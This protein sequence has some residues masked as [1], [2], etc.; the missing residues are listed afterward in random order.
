MQ[1]RVLGSLEVRRGDAPVAIGS[2][3]QRAV[4][5][6]LLAE[7]GKVVPVD[8]LVEALWGAQPPA[9][10]RN[11][12]Q[13]YVA[14]LREK[15]GPDIPIITRAPGYALEV[16][17]RQVDAQRFEQLLAEG[18]RRSAEPAAARV[19]LDRALG[20]W[21]GPAYAEFADDVARAEA[22][23]LAERRRVAIEERA[24][25]RLAL[26]EAADLVGELSAALDAEPL[27]ERLVGLLM[28]ALAMADRQADALAVYRRYRERLVDETGLEPSP[29]VRALEARVLRGE[30][31]EPVAGSAA[32][33]APSPASAGPA[34]PRV[35]RTP[36]GT[37]SAAPAM[38]TSLVGR[39]ADIADVRA[40]LDRAGVVTLTGPGGVGKTRIAAE[41]ARGIERDGGEV[42]WVE[43]A[44]VGDPAAVDHVVAAAV[45]VDLT[46]GQ[47][48]RDALLQALAPRTLLLVLDNCEHLPE[49]VAPL[50]DAIGRRCP[51]VRVLATGRERL[52]IDGEWLHPVRP[53]AVHTAAG[54]P[55]GAVRLFA[56]RA[57]AANASIDL[58]G[59]LDVVSDICRHVDGLPL[60]IELAAARTSVLGVDDL[61]A[62]LH[63]DL[64][65]AGHRRGGSERHRD[66]WAVADWSYRLLSTDE[67][68]LFER[69]S[70]F[71]GAFGADEAHAVCAPDGQSRPATVQQLATLAEGSV[72][73]FTGQGRY[74]MLRPLR[75]FARQRL[76]DR[77]ELGTVAD[78]HAAL[79][80]ECAEQAGGPPLTDDGRRWLEG[81]L[82]DLRG[83]RQRARRR[84]D[85][86]LLGRLVAALYRFD[87]WR[88]G[89]ELLGWADDA[90]ELEGMDDEPTA[91]QVYAAAATAA[92]RRGDLD[93]ARRLADR[94]IDLSPG[95]DDPAMAVPFE[96]L[97]DVANF[98][99]RLAEAEAA[100]REQAR[101]ARLGGDPD[102]EVLGMAS[103]ALVVAYAGRLAEG[104]GQA[105]AAAEAAAGAGPAVRA[106][107]RYAQGECRAE[108]APEEAQAILDDAG[109]LASA[110]GASFVETVA[111][112]TG[113][114]LRGRSGDPAAA[115][116][117][118]ADVIEG[119][120]RSGNW[121]QQWTTLRNFV[122]L[123]V[124]L[125]A[126]EPAVVIAAAAEAEQTAAPTFGA[127]GERL[128]R[129][130]QAAQARLGDLRAEAARARGPQLTA[131]EV[132]D[133]ALATIADLAARQA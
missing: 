67:Q 60:A 83:A 124:R 101:L 91:P 4:L 132:V 130:L 75:A 37:A 26:G 121:T 40:L 106:F 63:A 27:R 111:R 103:G 112:L 129:A 46:G 115:L 133:L 131:D 110:C 113:T 102:G 92:W 128:G 69:L 71:A 73:T 5:V 9:D 72:L 78:R 25:A 108:T 12:I 94:G 58:T 48:S 120:R 53:L 47:P 61:R 22:L 64:A 43:L 23:R 114:S 16:A 122:E 17:P 35:E 68:Q 3:R 57:A 39:E 89:G 55:E 97:G 51:H 65:A 96:A 74:R 77:G 1:V 118:F 8:A 21:R 126:D 34:G 87:Y 104:V 80:T 50:V 99:G 62:A 85:T 49:A 7:A 41:V 20:L 10:P 79:F 54:T 33:S 14:R 44:P 30:L 84:A 11:A 105:D 66:L 123:L 88:P 31:D 125:E 98:Q 107:A 18:Q 90:L 81:A 15:L 100:F 52:A 109:A 117:F 116:P 95:P 38:P 127:Q 32:P 24:A 19:L 119:W 29:G 70:V 56:E 76:A 13:T 2:R 36:A 59:H 42:A 28:Q 6:A 45:G 93:R 82:D 86:A